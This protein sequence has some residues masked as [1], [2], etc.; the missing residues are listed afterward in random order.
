MRQ[1]VSEDHIEAEAVRGTRGRS[2]LPTVEP[3]IPN[4]KGVN[5]FLTEA[6]NAAQVSFLGSLAD[7]GRKYMEEQ[8]TLYDRMEVAQ[9]LANIDEEFFKAS[10]EFLKTNQTGRGY[11]E[12]ATGKYK[13]LSDT[14]VSSSSNEAV[15]NA[16]RYVFL[17]RRTSIANSAFQKEKEMYTGYAMSQTELQLARTLNEVAENPD[18]AAS[19]GVKLEQQLLP[20]KN[21]LAAREFDKYRKEKIQQ[22]I[23][24]QGLG[25]VK[26]HPY[27]AEQLLRSE[28]FKQLDPQKYFSLQKSARREREHQER[29]KEHFEML[30]RQVQMRESESAFGRHELAIV[31][32]KESTNDFLEDPLLTEHQK[33][34]LVKLY[35]KA[36]EVH[37]KQAA[38]DA[39][40]AGA[41]KTGSA[42]PL[43]ITPQQQSKYIL[44]YIRSENLKRA[45]QNKKAM[46]SVEIVRYLDRGRNTFSAACMPLVSR[47]ENSIR[48]ST[49]AGEIFNTACAI[50]SGINVPT[51]Q[52]IDKDTKMVS[53][54]IVNAY[55]GEQNAPQ[56]IALRDE[57]MN[58]ETSVAETRKKKWKEFRKNDGKSLL[59]FVYEKLGY[60][61]W[62]G[63]KIGDSPDVS[64]L[65]DR[66]FSEVEYAGEKTGD[67]TKACVIANHVINRFVKQ[68]KSGNYMVNPPT[69]D[70]TGYDT[71][72]LNNI[73]SYVK[74][75]SVN[76]AIKAGFEAD[77]ADFQKNLPSFR[78]DKK[79]GKVN[80]EDII[81]GKLVSKRRV[82]IHPKFLKGVKGLDES[83]REVHMES[84]SL[85]EPIYCFYYL[86]DEKKPETRQ[87]L[88]DNTGTKI[89]FN[90]NHIRKLLKR[91]EKKQ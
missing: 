46:S 51:I 82:F 11:T 91:K 12:F 6:P 69:P 5:Q 20:M 2:S 45:E 13:E 62:F 70:N 35:N 4:F 1:I 74:Q 81:S 84:A 38:T 52:S 19:L 49:D 15:G 90:Y 33:S 34:K 76:E 22:F 77:S 8:Q 26:K 10:D 66:L 44:E 87:Y 14:A 61:K 83:E 53:A 43:E 60:A 28:Y 78:G 31:Q 3:Y 64:I 7:E 73:T 63:N 48:N 27:Q 41:L 36:Q 58:V 56:I 59:K 32:L 24:F 71:G 68:D 23:E 21:I 54:L 39:T 9:A 72:P 65:E 18:Q 88:Y 79:L 16:L 25:L 47:F 67:P 17:Q 40:I 85:D 29:L 75:L 50:Q 80:P 30:Q 57:L 89:L 55:E 37:S 42:L 86:L